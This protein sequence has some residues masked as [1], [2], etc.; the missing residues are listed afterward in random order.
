VHFDY[1][2]DDFMRP[3]KMVS[4]DG[5][6]ELELIPFKERVATSNLVLIT[7]EVHQMFGHYRGRL[8]TDEG[9]TIQ[10]R[11]FVGF[12]EEHHAQW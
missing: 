1:D 8:V 9:Q 3:W 5:R 6:L 7:S 12:A 11:E 4:E 10:I 2:P